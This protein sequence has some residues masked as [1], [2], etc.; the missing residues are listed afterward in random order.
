MLAGRRNDT[1]EISGQLSAMRKVRMM[2][3]AVYVLVASIG[4]TWGVRTPALGF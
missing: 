2:G 1:E 3:D 4:Y